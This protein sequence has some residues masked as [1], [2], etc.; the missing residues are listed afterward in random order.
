MS[1]QSEPTETPDV[2]VLREGTEGLSMASYADAL[3]DRLPDRTVAHARTPKEEREL[4]PEARVVT[5]I[6]LEEGLLTR[7]DR[8]ELFA[9]TFAGTDH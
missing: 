2:V 6:S 8:L 5:G 1:T 3:R 9:C 7:A 4:V